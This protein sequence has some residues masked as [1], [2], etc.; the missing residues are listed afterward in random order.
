MVTIVF[1]TRKDLRCQFVY[2]DSYP[3][4]NLAEPNS[5]DWNCFVSLFK[6]EYS[7]TYITMLLLLVCFT[8]ISLQGII[9]L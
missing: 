6:E 9:L 2:L 3:L 5:S 4:S 7:T 1:V 8:F